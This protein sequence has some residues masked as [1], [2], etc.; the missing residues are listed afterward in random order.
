MDETVDPHER[1]KKAVKWGM[2]QILATEAD[3]NAKDEDGRTPLHLAVVSAN[4]DVYQLLVDKGANVNA[5][6]RDGRTP[7]HL[8]VESA[9]AD[10][11]KFL[12]DKGADINAKDDKSGFTSLERAVR[13]G[14]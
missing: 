2:H 9:D 14:K 12:L 3:V 10:V 7:L 4:R 6:D 5:K 8:A 1:I 11:I 13:F